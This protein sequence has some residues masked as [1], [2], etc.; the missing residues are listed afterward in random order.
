M[1]AAGMLKI[2][3]ATLLL[4]LVFVNLL[5]LLAMYKDKRRAEYGQ[6][7]IPERTLL[8]IAFCGGSLGALVGQQIFRHKTAKQPFRAYLFA[9]GL[10]H[11]AVMLVWII[12]SLNSAASS[13]ASDLVSRL[14]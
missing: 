9:I 2:E 7:R 4:L 10:L 3:P 6:H 12:P 13:L 5:A 1:L 14:G 8:Q 11:V